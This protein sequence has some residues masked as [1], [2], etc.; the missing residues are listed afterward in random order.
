MMQSKLSAN[1]ENHVLSD[2]KQC[3]SLTT[4]RIVL[5]FQVH[6]NTTGQKKVQQS[7][8]T[9]ALAKHLPLARLFFMPIIFCLLPSSSI[10]IL[11]FYLFSTDISEQH[12]WEL[13]VWIQFTNLT[14]PLRRNPVNNAIT[15]V[16]PVHTRGTFFAADS[17]I[18]CKFPNSFLRKP[19]R[20]PIRCR[21]RNI[22]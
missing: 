21:A 15:L 4:W 11:A 16:S 6:Y 20:Q 7:W 10:V 1:Y 3:F 5:Y 22:F 14:L 12:V 2:W 13:W 9:S 17:N 8:Q 19:E 18:L